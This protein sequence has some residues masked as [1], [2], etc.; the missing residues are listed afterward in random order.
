MNYS[1]QKFRKVIEEIGEAWIASKAGVAFISHI[2]SEEAKRKGSVGSVK[3]PSKF[4]ASVEPPS[5]PSEV[6]SFMGFPGIQWTK[7]HAIDALRRWL[8]FLDTE[9]APEK[10]IGWLVPTAAQEE[11]KN[12]TSTHETFHLQAISNAILSSVVVYLRAEALFPGS[13]VTKSITNSIREEQYGMRVDHWPRILDDQTDYSNDVNTQLELPAPY[14]GSVNIPDDV[15]DYDQESLFRAPRDPGDEDEIFGDDESDAEIISHKKVATRLQFGPGADVDTPIAIKEE[16]DDLHDQFLSRLN[17][18][19]TYIVDR[20]G[21]MDRIIKE[22]T[23]IQNNIELRISDEMKKD[24]IFYEPIQISRHTARSIASPYIS[25]YAEIMSSLD[26]V[27]QAAVQL[28]AI[29]HRQTI[30]GAESFRLHKENERL[31][32]LKDRLQDELRTAQQ[33][34]DHIKELK[35][36]TEAKKLEIQGLQG[37]ISSVKSKEATL[38]SKPS[39]FTASF[40]IADYHSYGSYKAFNASAEQDR[41][42]SGSADG[43]GSTN[44]EDTHPSSNTPITIPT[45]AV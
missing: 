5:T 2:K 33:M 42:R 37:E 3:A 32:A 43:T 10:H 8:V 38:I 1:L 19:D 25:R 26:P 17:D 28:D 6:L 22:A 30:I 13:L 15:H 16:E 24:G 27:A 9:S 29:A 7:Y 11:D 36:K 20:S 44:S 4:S 14:A 18:D 45:A 31:D 41:A 23:L 40:G 12:N 34:Q 39:F 35:S 21:N